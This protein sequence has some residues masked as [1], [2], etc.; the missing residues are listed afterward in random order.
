MVNILPA[1]VC[2]VVGL[3]LVEASFL[4]WDSMGDW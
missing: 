3:I 1:M 2:L 4:F